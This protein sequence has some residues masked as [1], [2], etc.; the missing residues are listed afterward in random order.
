MLLYIRL[1]KENVIVIDPAKGKEKKTVDEFFDSF[2]G[3]LLLL[4]PNNEFN[5]GKVKGQGLV[6]TE[7]KSH[8]MTKTSGEIREVFIEEG[9]ELPTSYVEIDNEEMEYVDGGGN[10]PTWA[11]SKPINLLLTLNP[12]VQLAFGGVTALIKYGIKSI[13]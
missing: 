12:G 8:I 4:I 1:K 6:A 3:V 7:N 9:L 13:A 2:D 11:I 10:I 5:P